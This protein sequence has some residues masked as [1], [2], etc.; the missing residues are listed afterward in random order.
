MK[1]YLDLPT[2]DYILMAVKEEESR[3]HSGIMCFLEKGK[4]GTVGRINTKNK[5][6]LREIIKNGKFCQQQEELSHFDQPR[7][8]NRMHK[9]H[10]W[11]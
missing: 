2:K 4:N 1:E 3:T 9:P 5:H 11:Y 10:L 8:L 7:S 6:S